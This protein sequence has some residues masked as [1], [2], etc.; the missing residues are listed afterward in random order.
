VAGQLVDAGL[1]RREYLV[2]CKQDSHTI[3]MVK[4]RADLE[5]GQGG[6]FTC[7]I[8]GRSFKDEQVHEVFALTD[9]GR[10][11]LAGSRWMTI[12]I[13]ELLMQSGVPKTDVAWNAIAGED[14]LDIMTD[15]LGPRVFFELKDREFGLGDAYPFAFRVNRYGGLFGVVVS[16]ERVAGE[17]KKFFEEQRQAMEAR[18]EWLEGPET[19]ARDL[20]GV[21]DRVSRSGVN[22]LL[23]DLSES[24]GMNLV[25]VARAWMDKVAQQQTAATPNLPLQPTG[26]GQDTAGG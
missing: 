7:S 2:M 12:W 5:T 11:Q 25:P 14:E 8:C 6:A 22:E 21:V 3:C 13:T 9:V 15:A 24:I 17:A 19:I 16:T 20:R 10:K 23:M 4:D 18:I 26:A 1:L